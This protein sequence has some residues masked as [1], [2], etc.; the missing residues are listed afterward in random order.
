MGRA[1]LTIEVEVF[2]FSGSVTISCEKKFAG[3]NGDPTLRQLMGLS[4]D[5]LLPL[6]DELALIDDETTYG[7]REYCDAFA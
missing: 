6:A 3:S 4:T 5:P 2:F 1:E 7:W